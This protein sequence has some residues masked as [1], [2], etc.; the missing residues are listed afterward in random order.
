M[1]QILH[2]YLQCILNDSR[3]TCYFVHPDQRRLNETHVIGCNFKLGESV[4]VLQFIRLK[5]DIDFVV[6]K[7][8]ASHYALALAPHL[9][10]RENIFQ[11]R[12]Q[13]GLHISAVV[14][15]N[16][17]KELGQFSQESCCQNQF[18]RL[19]G[20]GEDTCDVERPESIWNPWETGLMILLTGNYL[21]YS[22]N[23][24]SYYRWYANDL[25]LVAK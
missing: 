17:A 3:P 13:G 14:L 1:T 21:Q 6:R 4:G 22:V 20:E 24:D 25:L 10:L 5:V 23:A 8:P 11:L 7:H 12:S 18:S 16:N 2:P 19:S 15:I 9:S